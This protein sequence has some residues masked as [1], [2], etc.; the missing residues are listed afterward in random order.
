MGLVNPSRAP[1]LYGL[2]GSSLGICWKI[3]KTVN[4][5]V[6]FFKFNKGDNSIAISEHFSHFSKCFS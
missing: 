6:K 5:G 4:Q 2:S 1:R 3:K